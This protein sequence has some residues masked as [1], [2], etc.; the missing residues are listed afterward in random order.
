VILSW[1]TSAVRTPA[2][3]QTSTDERVTDYAKDYGQWIASELDAEVARRDRHEARGAALLTTSGVILTVLVAVRGFL[4]NDPIPTGRVESMALA[5]GVSALLLSSV[6][7]LIANM[8]KPR[9]LLSIDSL[10]NLVRE[11]RWTEDESIAANAHAQLRI[12]MI[13]EF[14]NVNKWNGR[15]LL[16]GQWVQLAGFVALGVAILADFWRY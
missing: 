8:L 14:R 13:T 2:W 5:V 6:L 15:I 12:Q 3:N 1:L 7:G 16:G 11:P 9:P 4:S 10:W